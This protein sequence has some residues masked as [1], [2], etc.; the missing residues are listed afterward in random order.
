MPVLKLNHVSTRGPRLLDIKHCTWNRHGWLGL[1]HFVARIHL[2]FNGRFLAVYDRWKPIAN[3]GDMMTPS[4]GNIFRVTCHLCGEFTGPRWIPRTKASDAELWFFSLICAWVD[5]WVNNREAG[6]SWTSLKSSR[7]HSRQ[8]STESIFQ[9]GEGEER[10]KGDKNGMAQMYC[11]GFCCHIHRYRSEK[12]TEILTCLIIR[13]T[14]KL[15]GWGWGWGWWGGVGWAGG[16]ILVSL[17]PSIRPSA[18]HPV[19]AL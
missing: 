16:G 5:G 7:G 14:T 13:T 1:R 17:R 15:W 19:P 3:L 9:S 8:N 10:R 18:P 12:A 2:G 11:T 4:N 6:H